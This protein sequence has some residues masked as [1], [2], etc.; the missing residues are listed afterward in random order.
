M[1]SQLSIDLLEKSL[2]GTML[3]ENY[4]ITDEV[5]RPDMFQSQIH[6]STYLA[7]QHLARNQ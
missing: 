7:M 5:M 4:L 2:L 3:R 6:R 1:S